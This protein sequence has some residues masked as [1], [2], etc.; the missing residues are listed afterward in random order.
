MA[1]SFPKHGHPAFGWIALTPLIIATW[2]ATSL[3]QAFF[4]GLLSGAVYFWGTLYW[5]VETMT[6]FGGLSV[7][8]AFVAAL[9]LVAYLSL[10][11]AGFAVLLARSKRAFGTHALALAA[12][13]WVTTELGRQYLW[14]GFPWALLGYS[15]VTVLPVAQ[16]ASAVGVYGLSALLAFAAAG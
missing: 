5:L 1:L 10:F 4:L 16:I 7:P 3:R 6:T 15:Q 9:L 2:R 12:P 8:V 13:I 11:P 14:D